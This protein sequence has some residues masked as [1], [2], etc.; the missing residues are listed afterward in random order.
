MIFLFIHLEIRND[1]VNDMAV[2]SISHLNNDISLSWVVDLAAEA[3]WI[4]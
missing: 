4:D 1:S 3:H 2:I